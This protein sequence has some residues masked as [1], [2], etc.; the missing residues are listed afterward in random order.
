MRR[1]ALICYCCWAC[2]VCAQIFDETGEFV[3]FSIGSNARLYLAC[4]LNALGRREVIAI[5]NCITQ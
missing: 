2:G 5:G 3:W 4:V 1:L